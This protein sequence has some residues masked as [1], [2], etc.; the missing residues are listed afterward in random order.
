MPVVTGGW[1]GLWNRVGN[2]QHALLV[3]FDYNTAGGTL[4]VRG[5]AINRQISRLVRTYGGRVAAE[6]VY[7]G[8]PNDY[9]QVASSAQPGNPIV[10]GGKI[11]INTFTPI[12]VTMNNAQN[13]VEKSN[14]PR[15]NAAAGQP[16]DQGY[17]VDRS[18]NGG[19]GK[20]G[21]KF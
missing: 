1:S 20:M 6:G 3:P 19:G 15:T 4:T 2:E 21:L 14:S 10:N 9:K 13:T 7:D 8:F 18:G 16:V 17:P 12:S 11:T 5:H